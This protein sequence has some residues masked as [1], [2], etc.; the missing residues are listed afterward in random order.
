MNDAVFY[1]LSLEYKQSFIEEYFSIRGKCVG[2]T[3][4]Q[5]GQIFILDKGCHAIPRY[6]CVKVAKPLKN[7]TLW[8]TNDRFLQEI[9]TQLTFYH[10][11]YVHWIFRIDIAMDAPIVWSR[12]WDGDLSDIIKENNQSLISK[13]SILIYICSGLKHCIDRGL[14][15][16]QD[17]KPQNIFIKDLAK[18]YSDLPNIDIYNVAMIADFGLANAF[19]NDIFDGARPYMSPEQWE[20]EPLTSKS[21]I[22][23]LGVI[24]CELLSGGYH[25]CGIK[26]NE[27][28]PKP[29]N[30][31]S[32]KWTREKPWK[33]WANGK[34]LVDNT[35]LNHIRDNELMNL[36]KKMLSINPHDRPNIEKIIELLLFKIH[37]LDDISY[38]NIQCQLD[39][40][41]NTPSEDLKTQWPSLF[42]DWETV[43]KTLRQ[44]P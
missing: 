38:Q 9:E 18:T 20:K 3:E 30:N 24:F 15:A 2:V 36:I 22:F 43:K 19:Q 10:N 33:K 4:G 6:V 1:N 5:C 26:L 32:A 17:L 44:K 40:F 13:L 8:E 39:H 7:E 34:T 12:Y 31:N 27:F 29:L 21:D 42:N 41:N 11:M 37:E 23:S 16:H 14:I 28:W 25:P 35:I